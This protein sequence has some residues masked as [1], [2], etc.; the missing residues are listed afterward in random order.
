MGQPSTHCLVNLPPLL[1]TVYPHTYVSAKTP[2]LPR[3][4]FYFMLFPAYSWT[5]ILWLSIPS[6]SVCTSWT[7][8][9]IVVICSVG[10]F[11]LYID[12]LVIRSR[13]FYQS[14]VVIDRTPCLFSSYCWMM[15]SPTRMEVRHIPS[16]CQ[17]FELCKI[18]VLW[19][20]LQGPLCWWVVRGSG[21]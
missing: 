16:A 13:V 14:F 21:E 17:T 18:T 11:S 1:D 15:Y 4:W 7:V 8:M 20:L 5:Q 12:G 10:F 3:L 6:L 19:V 9:V 2:Q